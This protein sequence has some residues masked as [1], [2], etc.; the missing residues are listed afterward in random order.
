MSSYF[1]NFTTIDIQLWPPPSRIDPKFFADYAL[2]P[3][4]LVPLLLV[5]HIVTSIVLQAPNFRD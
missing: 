1:L 5:Y 4:L 2:N 3:S